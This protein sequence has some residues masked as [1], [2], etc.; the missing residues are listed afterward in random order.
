MGT[1]RNPVQL[2]LG[3]FLRDEAIDRVERNAD[4]EFLD[5]ARLAIIQV[6]RELSAFTTDDIWWNLRLRNVPAPGD[7]RAMGAAIRRAIR[8]AIIRPAAE[9]PRRSVRT[10]CHSR[11]LRV[12]ERVR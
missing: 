1:G 4:Q 6:A 7:P 3:E 2:T 11:P 12:W 9:F 5:S 10:T 8:E